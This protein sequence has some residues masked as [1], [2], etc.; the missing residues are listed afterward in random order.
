ML[1]INLDLVYNRMGGISIH[2]QHH[3]TIEMDSTDLV[4][5]KLSKDGVIGNYFLKISNLMNENYQRPH[6]YNQEERRINIGFKRSY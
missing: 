6:G 1:D 5:I 3:C 2:I 4:D